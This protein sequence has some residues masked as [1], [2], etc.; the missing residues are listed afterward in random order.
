MSMELWVFQS[1]KLS[2]RVILDFEQSILC[3]VVPGSVQ[4]CDSDDER[5]PP[6]STQ[7]AA[8]LAEMAAEADESRCSQNPS[9]QLS[10]S[11]SGLAKI[12]HGAENTFCD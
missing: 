12:L 8:V 1:K 4:S 7:T 6:P 2:I 10:V 9:T 3:L 11:V 5:Q